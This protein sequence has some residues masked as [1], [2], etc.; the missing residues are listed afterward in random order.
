MYGFITLKEN[1]KRPP[2]IFSS[3]SESKVRSIKIHDLMNKPIS[4]MGSVSFCIQLEMRDIS[5]TDEA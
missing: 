2:L 5:H 4:Y 1:Y 3:S